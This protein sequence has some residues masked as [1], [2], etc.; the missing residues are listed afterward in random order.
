L[1]EQSL[2]GQQRILE[3]LIPRWNERSLTTSWHAAS[4]ESEYELVKIEEN[5]DFEVAETVS[6]DTI[7]YIRDIKL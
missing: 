6:I 4:M 7:A 2:E 1:L 5:Y 3:K